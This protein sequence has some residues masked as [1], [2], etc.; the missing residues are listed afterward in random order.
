MSSAKLIWQ[1]LC[2]NSDYIWVPKI[3][4]L[5]YIKKYEKIQEKNYSS[6]GK[7]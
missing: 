2:L 5:E 1:K 4:F 7:T 6:V 3:T